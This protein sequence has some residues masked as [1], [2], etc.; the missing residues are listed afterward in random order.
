MS[1]LGSTPVDELTRAIRA[2]GD[3]ALGWFRRPLDIDD[4]GTGHR[5]D[6]VTDADRT[7]EAILRREIG[8]RYPGDAIL[9]EEEGLTGSGD[10]CWII[11]PI[12][13]TR[14]FVSGQPLWGTLV[15]LRVGD[16]VVA[17]WNHLPALG[18]TYVAADGTAQLLERDGSR[19]SLATSATADLSQAIVGCT[20][21][22]MFPTPN[23][24]S[25]FGAIADAVRMVRFG[26][27]CANYGLVALGTMDLVIEGGL[28]P[29]D[30]AAHIP[31]IEAAG[32]VVIGLA[33]ASRTNPADGGFVITAAN[34]ALADAAIEL[35]AA[36]LG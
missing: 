19:R 21:P 17:G 4:K 10:R 13:G 11:D 27:D 9:G 6:P 14:S 24:R 23:E 18:E 32:G 12:D 26:G 31:I 29:Y 35:A 20:H 34:Q 1:A 22:A 2:A 3:R 33:G 30:I 16:D 36:H 8:A 28:H 25:A 15:G 5:F 7:V